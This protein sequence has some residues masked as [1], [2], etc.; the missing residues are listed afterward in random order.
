MSFVGR[1]RVVGDKNIGSA[2]IT[3]KRPGIFTGL[4]RSGTFGVILKARNQ[5]RKLLGSL[6][7]EVLS[8]GV[9]SLRFGR[10]RGIKLARRSKRSFFSICYGSS[11]N[12]QFL[13]RV[14]VEGRPR[15]GGQTICCS[16]FTVRSRTES[17]GEVRGRSKEG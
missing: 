10:A 2:R 8:L 17:T 14:R 11:C 16:S 7:G 1:A 4:A 5:D 6:L 3:T 9:I 13:I 15:F 12:E